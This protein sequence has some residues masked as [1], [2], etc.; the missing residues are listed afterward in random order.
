MKIN[1]RGFWENETAEGHGHDEGLATALVYFFNGMD[2]D[3]LLDVGCGDAYYIKKLRSNGVLVTG[4]DGNPNT[5]KLT[6]GYGKVADLTEPQDFGM[7]DWVLSLEVGEHIPQEFQNIFIDNLDKHNKYGIVLSWAVR[8]QGGD[9]HVNCLNNDEVIELMTERG[10]IYDPE[11][12]QWLRVRCA[13][14]P[15][16]GWWFRNTVVVFR[17]P[18]PEMCSNGY[19]FSEG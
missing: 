6:D 8:G 11:S 5:P 9:G 14:Y 10:Y 16:T 13:E 4:V 18:Q 3:T 15:N 19:V 12:T 17:K 7:F 2:I 1:G